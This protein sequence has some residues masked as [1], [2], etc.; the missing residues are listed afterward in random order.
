[1]NVLCNGRYRVKQD[2]NRYHC[3]VHYEN[4]NYLIDD[5]KLKRKETYY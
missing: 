1:M 5:R 2:V 4:E 3:N